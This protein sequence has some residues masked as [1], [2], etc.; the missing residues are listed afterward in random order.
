MSTA[1]LTTP[2]A[3]RFGR[4]IRGGKHLG[5]R[6]LIV[7][8]SVLVLTGLALQAQRA[9]AQ[10]NHAHLVGSWQVTITFTITETKITS[11]GLMT[12]MADGNL[13]ASELLQVGPTGF[14]PERETTGHG[15]WA[16]LGGGTYAYTFTSLQ[17]NQD[18]HLAALLTYQ[19]HVTL[20]PEANAWS[21]PIELTPFDPTGNV[22]QPVSGTVEA[23]RIT[24][25]PF[26]RP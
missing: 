2:A 21:G 25:D 17:A 10:A 26:A 7:G 5:L 11:R 1:A 20:S 13:V 23:T 12:V 3:F 4:Q 19:G 15:T 6:L 22:A 9:G 24:V 16:S 8:L 14:G 18:G